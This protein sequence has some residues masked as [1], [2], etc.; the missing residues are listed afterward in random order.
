V[1]DWLQILR[2]PSRCVLSTIYCISTVNTQ[3]TQRADV[4][5]QLAYI[6]RFF[7]WTQVPREESNNGVSPDVT[8][9]I[10]P[11]SI[12]NTAISELYIVLSV[13]Y[14]SIITIR[15]NECKQF[16]QHILK[17][18]TVLSK[19]QYYLQYTSWYAFRPLTAPSWGSPKLYSCNCALTE[20]RA[21]RAETRSSLCVVILSF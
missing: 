17:L 16:Y 1:L 14:N 6:S 19:S 7:R 18:I 11:P 2:G 3:H 21:I 5:V 12:R 8:G 15:A 9:L 4:L 10:H 20:D 13:H